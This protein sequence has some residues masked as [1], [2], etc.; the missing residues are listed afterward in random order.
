MRAYIPSTGD[1]LVRGRTIDTNTAEIARALAAEGAT[2]IGASL[3][4]DDEEAL[5][6]AILAAAEAAEL[7]VMSGG[8]GPTVDDC[9]RAAAARAARVAL[10]RRPEIVAD[11]E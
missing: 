3:V 7:V 11:L 8:L 9:T 2:V 6:R 4:G 5:A 1:E 10:V